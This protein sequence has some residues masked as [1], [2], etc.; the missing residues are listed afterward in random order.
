MGLL[1]IAPSGGEGKGGQTKQLPFLAPGAQK[2]NVSHGGGK[3][4]GDERLK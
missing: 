4:M 3:G 2:E 1:R